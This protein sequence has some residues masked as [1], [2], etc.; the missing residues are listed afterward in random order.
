MGV[1]LLLIA[2]VILALVTAFTTGQIALW[3]VISIGF[4]NSVMFPTIFSTGSKDLNKGELSTASGIINSL[5]QGGASY[6][7]LWVR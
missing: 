6:S 7:L 1:L 4:V 2:L 3:T 5:V